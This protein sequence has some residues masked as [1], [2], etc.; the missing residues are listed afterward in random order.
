M[1][2]TYD[3]V[4]SFVFPAHIEHPDATG[5]LELLA[6]HGP[7]TTDGKLFGGFLGRHEVQDAEI[8][9]MILQHATET[10][11]KLIGPCK[12]AVVAEAVKKSLYGSRLSKN[13]VAD[14]LRTVTILDSGCLDFRRLQS[15]VLS[16]HH[17]RIAE[18]CDQLSCKSLN[19]GVVK[20]EV[21]YRHPPTLQ[22]TRKQ[23]K[24]GTQHPL[25]TSLHR[26]VY[27]ITDIHDYAPTEALRS[28][29]KL[30]RPAGPFG[31]K[32]DRSCATRN[33]GKESYVDSAQLPTDAAR[34][35]L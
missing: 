33:T 28:N 34:L 23:K 7:V 2:Q 24:S 26:G 31:D 6:L 1:S 20:N 8:S 13:D 12:D 11:K 21:V 27:S 15:V 10:A 35:L 14:I 29:I 16:L 32:W 30:I 17:A 4:F 19:Q 5:R 9:G 25:L 18:I 22:Y 3:G